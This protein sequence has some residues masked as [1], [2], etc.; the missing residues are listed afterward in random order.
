MKMK[1]IYSILLL[2]LVLNSF[3]QSKLAELLTEQQKID[4]LIEQV[5]ALSDAMFIRNGT[6]HDAKAAATH[7]RM[8][9]EKAGKAIKTVDD[10][11]EKVASKSSILQ[12]NP[13]K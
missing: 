3:T 4:Y 8:K 9:R 1:Y 7:L 5:E 13:I 11:I 6:S 10:F 12:I 2:L